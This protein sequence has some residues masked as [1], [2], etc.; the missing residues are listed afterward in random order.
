V[1]TSEYDRGIDR[2]LE[3][4]RL[5]N[6][7]LVVNTNGIDGV[8]VTVMKSTVSFVDFE[9]DTVFLGKDNAIEVA[10]AILREYDVPFCNRVKGAGVEQE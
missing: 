6:G 1:A 4:N 9:D 8:E 2:D 10:K 3:I 7:R 5:G